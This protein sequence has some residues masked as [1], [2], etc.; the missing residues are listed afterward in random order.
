MEQPIHIDKTLDARGLSCP[1]PIVK[2]R[3]TVNKMEPGQ[4]LQVLSTDRGSMKD[5][6]GWARSTPGVEL[7]KQETT[8]EGEQTIYTH[9]IVKAK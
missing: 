7:L 5:F 9:Y 8:T 2:A 6:E 1:M 3:L 4:V